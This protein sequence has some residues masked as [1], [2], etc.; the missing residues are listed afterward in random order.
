MKMVG[1]NLCHNREEQVIEK[2]VVV[3]DIDGKFPVP[4]HT[5]DEGFLP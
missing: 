2:Q 4:E 5:N 1:Q 3:V